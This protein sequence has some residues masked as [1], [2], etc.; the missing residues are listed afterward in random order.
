MATIFPRV[1]I[2]SKYKEVWPQAQNDQMI[3]NV[4]LT[5]S[6]HVLR[7]EEFHSSRQMSICGSSY[8]LIDIDKQA[9]GLPFLSTVSEA[10][11]PSHMLTACT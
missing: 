3:S 4:I 10:V 9:L 8:T 1:S 2:L 11:G 5:G 6:V 7:A